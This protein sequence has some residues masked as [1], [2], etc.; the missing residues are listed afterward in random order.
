M[1]TKYGLFE[2]NRDLR[3]VTYSRQACDAKKVTDNRTEETNKP[4]PPSS[5]V[6]LHAVAGTCTRDISSR[7]VLTNYILHT[8]MHTTYIHIQ[9]HCL[10]SYNARTG[11]DVFIRWSTDWFS[12]L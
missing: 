11:S 2:Y 9:L 4:A 7:F 5:L 6:C 1:D 8:S 10:H 12:M 3:T